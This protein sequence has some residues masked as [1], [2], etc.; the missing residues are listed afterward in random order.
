[1][2]TPKH[3]LERNKNWA[4]KVRQQD[5]N[6]FINLSK[7]QKPKCLWISCSDSRVSVNQITDAQ[8]GE[9]FVH[10][11]IANL[12]NSSDL[13]CI[14]TIQFAVEVLKVKHIIVCG[15]YGCGGIEASMKDKTVHGCIDDWL[16][17][18][19]DIY[20]DNKNTIDR[21]SGIEKLDLLCELNVLAQVRNVYNT[22]SIQNARKQGI[23]ID[24]HGW[25]YDIRNGGLKDL[26]CMKEVIGGVIN[27]HTNKINQLS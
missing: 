1:M 4:R 6:F 3:L 25:I 2:N 11:N 10:R 26:Q 22:K 18:L 14:S 27:D 8:P 7:Q 24:I 17:P 15:H 5:P 12:V 16:L 20:R 19:N 23:E 9:F 21:L 13:S